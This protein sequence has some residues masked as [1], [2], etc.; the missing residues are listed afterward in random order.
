[1]GANSDQPKRGRHSLTSLVR[2]T[3]K[4]VLWTLAVFFSLMTFPSS[5]PWMLLIWLIIHGL[6]IVRSKNS[7]GVLLI[8]LLVFCVKRPP[9]FLETIIFVCLMVCAVAI[10]FVI[11]RRS[12]ANLEVNRLTRVSKLMAVFLFVGIVALIWRYNTYTTASE[13]GTW[14]TTKPVVCLGDS[15]T[16]YGYP[17]VLSQKISAPVLD[18]GENGIRTDRG[19]KRIEEII[20]ANPQAVVLELGGHDYNQGYPRRHAKQNLIQMIEAFQQAGIVVILVEI[21]RGFISDPFDG[22]ERQLARKYDLQLVGDGI[23][24]SFVLM[25]PVIPPGQWVSKDRHYSK[26]GLHPNERGNERFASTIAQAL[27]QVFGPEVRKQ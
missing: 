8:G 27:E 18:F 20:Q 19:V 24:R 2:F 17:K 25:S 13:P 14:N 15:L 21:P 3:A 4:A 16:A 10:G 11:W 23:I 9:L 12:K 7:F 6:A 1:M 22:L 26:D 5:A